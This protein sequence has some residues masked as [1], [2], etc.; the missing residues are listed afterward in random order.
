[1]MHDLGSLGGT[2]GF[3][4]WMNNHGQVVG[5][6]SLAGDNSFHPFLWDGHRLIDL[7]TLGGDFGFA[8]W[9]NDSGTVVGQADLPGGQASHGFLWSHGAMQDLPPTAGDLCSVANAINARGQAV[10]A[11]GPCFGENQN[12]ML[13]ENG[14]SLDLNSLIAPSALHLTEAFFIAANGEIACLGTVPTGDMHVAVLTPAA[15]GASGR[16]ARA[17]ST[18]ATTESVLAQAT[19]NPFERA[20]TGWERLALIAKRRLR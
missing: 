16:L 11:E 5:I 12:A 7:G 14:A 9:V 6:A 19:P 15:A 18:T 4:N 13:W 3:T 10:G 17:S 8:T 20:A 1:M 2:L